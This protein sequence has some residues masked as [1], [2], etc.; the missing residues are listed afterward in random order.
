[1]AKKVL[2][3]KVAIKK[4]VTRKPSR[5]AGKTHKSKAEEKKPLSQMSD[6]TKAILTVIGGGILGY[7]MYKLFDK[8]RVDDQIAREKV[9]EIISKNCSSMGVNKMQMVNEIA[10]EIKVERKKRK[11]AEAKVTEL[12]SKLQTITEELERLAKYT[13]KEEVVEQKES[14][15]GNVD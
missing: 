11:E 2:E 15:N 13:K 3:K 10:R 1:M 7:L 6:T 5:G 9:F 12:E 4:T 14:E 8:D